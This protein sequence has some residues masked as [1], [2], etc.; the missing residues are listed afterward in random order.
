[1]SLASREKERRDHDFIEGHFSS[2]SC[3]SSIFRVRPELVCVS[4]H[5]GQLSLIYIQVKCLANKWPRLALLGNR[6]DS[7]LDGFLLSVLKIT[8]YVSRQY[9]EQHLIKSTQFLLGSI[10]FK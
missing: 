2:A 7:L 1:M 10:F 9:A 6:G 4:E 3:S 5:N 8:M